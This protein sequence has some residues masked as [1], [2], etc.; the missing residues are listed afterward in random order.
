MRVFRRR[1]RFARRKRYNRMIRRRIGEKPGTL[2]TKEHIVADNQ[3]HRPL[4]KHL[5][6]YDISD[7]PVS[8]IDD[9][10]ER[11][12]QFVNLRGWRFNLELSNVQATKD[13]YLNWAIVHMKNSTQSGSGFVADESLDLAGLGAFS[14]DFFRDGTQE[15]RSLNFNNTTQFW[16]SIVYNRYPLNPD[17]FNILAHRRVKI[18]GTSVG[19]SSRTKKIWIPLRRQIR[20]YDGSSLAYDRTYFLYWCDVPCNPATATPPT[21]QPLC[22]SFYCHAVFRE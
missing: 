14:Q 15:S 5:N 11:Q 7:I 3:D 2:T 10:N 19:Y 12:R 16:D 6:V 21:L 4:V 18:P 9:E 22:I 13:V 17:K 20:Y 8:G 1:R